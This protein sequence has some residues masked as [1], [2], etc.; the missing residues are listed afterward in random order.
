MLSHNE[1]FLILEVFV[2]LKILYVFETLCIGE[3]GGWSSLLP[4][5]QICI[6]VVLSMVSK[7]AY[8]TSSSF[9]AFDGVTHFELVK[10][11]LT[12]KNP[13]ELVHDTNYQHTMSHV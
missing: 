13:N 8:A 6:Y 7:P 3:E 10:G 4:L 1:S 5:P 11:H 2:E 9:D 12:R